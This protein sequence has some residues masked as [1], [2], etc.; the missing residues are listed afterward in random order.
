MRRS[1][2]FIAAAVLLAAAFAAQA[3][4]AFAVKA[5][6]SSRAA[7]F[8]V[9]IENVSAADGQ[10]AKDG[11]RWPFA[12]SPGLYVAG[13][14]PVALFKEGHKASAGL[15]SQAED[16]NPS[17][18]AQALE[19]VRRDGHHGVFHTPVGAGAPAPIGPGG[20]Y[21]FTFD[22][23][24]GD[25]L[26]VFTMFGQSND[27]FYSNAKPVA[28]FDSKGEPVNGDVTEAFALYDAG[29]EVNE[30]PG[31]GAAQAPR[32]KS[33]NT[34]SAEHGVVRRASGEAFYART[35][36]LFRVTITPVN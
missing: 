36:Q 9:R 25:V 15:E 17:G 7:T 24:Q 30:E 33:P 26:T 5:K 4:F 13:A 14:K 19:A 32:Q 23:A 18:L 20:A 11:T 35:P 34:G 1:K 3:S 29:T 27:Y 12:L 10:T 6:K 16:G 2:F 8:R 21:E 28:L 22:A 31:V